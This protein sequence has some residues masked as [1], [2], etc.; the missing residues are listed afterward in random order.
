MYHSSVVVDEDPMD[1]AK[2]IVWEKL[3]EHLPKGPMPYK[4]SPVRNSFYQ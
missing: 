4:L 2:E 1:V 3:M